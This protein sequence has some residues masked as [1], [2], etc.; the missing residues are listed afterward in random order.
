MPSLQYFGRGLTR[1]QSEALQSTQQAAILNFAHDRRHVWTAMKSALELMHAL[2]E[3]TGGVIWD[4]ATR[5]VFSPEQWKSRRIDT[6][7]GEVPPIARHTVIH[8]YQDNE[9]ARAIS[10]GM[11]KFGLPDAVVNS[12]PWSLNRNMGITLNLFA[13][14]IAEGAQVARPGE[15]NLDIRSIKNAAV[16]D[17]QVESLLANATGIALL[18]LH[19][20]TAEEGDPENRLIE[21]TFERGTGPDLHARQEQILAAAFGWEDEVVRVQH[22]R[23]LEQASQQA[24]AKLPELRAEFQKGLAPGEF[25][26]LKAPFKTPDGGREWMWV[27]VIS[28]Q[29]DKITGLLK[30][31]PRDIPTLH[32]GQTVEVSEATIFDYIRKHADGSSD[33]NETSRLIEKRGR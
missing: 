8:A 31:E 11:E 20:G 4:E 3:A 2:A 27:E 12:F 10:L 7:E 30:N 19:Q 29:G 16:R 5:E 14:A 18:G 26:Q 1:E 22:N 13:Q 25:I 17:P 21:L 24:R 15:F 32:G 28:W 33:G 6:W 9:Y 23:E